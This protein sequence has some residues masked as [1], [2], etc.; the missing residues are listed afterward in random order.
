MFQKITATFACWLLSCAAFAQHKDA[1]FLDKAQFTTG[2]DP[3]WSFPGFDDKTWKTLQTGQVWQAQGFDN[4]HGFA[5]YRIHVFVPS[6]LREN[7]FWKDS[8]RL[9]L[10]HVNDVDETYFN[11]VKV[12]KTGAFPDDA[13]GYVSKW[14]ATREYHIA[15]EAAA[16]KW[17]AENIISIKVYDGGGTGGIFMGAPYIDMLEKTDGLAITMAA[18]DIRYDADKATLTLTVSN[19]YSVYFDGVLKTKIL[20]AAAHGIIT[21]KNAVLHI[22]PLD[23]SVFHFTVPNRP[24]VEISWS[25]TQ[26]GTT[27]VR[28]EKQT[29]PYTLTPSPADLPRIN[30]A[31]VLGLHPGSPVLFKIAATGKKP[32]R[33]AASGLP[34]GVQIDPSTGMIGGVVTDSGSYP[35]VI[36]VSNSLGKAQQHFNIVAG[37]RLALTPPMGWNS[38]NCWGIN[39]SAD[40]VMQSAQALI[41]KGLIDYGWTYINIDDGWQKPVR[42]TDSSVVPNEKFD[43]MMALGTWLHSRGLKFGIYSSPGPRTCGGY[44]GSYRN[45]EKDASTYAAWGVD[46]LKYDWCSYDEIAR[47]DSALT[48][49]I[50]PYSIMD[51]ALQKQKRD[52]V[53]NLCQYGMRD[54]WKW[55]SQVHAQSWRTTEDIEDTWQSFSSI[56]FGQARLYPYAGPGHWNDPDMMIVGKV[57]WG[58]DLHPTRLTPDEQYTHVSLWCLLSAPL[59][60][61]CD[62]SKLDA[63]TRNLLTNSEVLA[64]DQDVLGS[65]A[66][67]MVENDSTQVWVKQ[68]ADG[69][70]AIGVFNMTSGYSH[71][72]LPWKE[73]GFRRTQRVRDA[74][75]Q[76]SLGTVQNVPRLLLPPHGSVLLKLAS[77]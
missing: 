39:V 70:K 21:Q 68:L 4:Y 73:L 20:D 71:V 72:R 61:G 3:A 69:G 51:E 60:I 38:W 64:I 33:Y 32:L 25:F 74:W 40:K 13:G 9:F 18:E 26:T 7:A 19:S 66:Q 77:N 75:R 58:Q 57:G 37:A 42:A 11:G 22:R 41:D 43:D 62:L 45:E 30:S 53:Y 63:F 47:N 56:G 1:I 24:G 14:P 59:L 50:K 17:D 76:K 52:I 44:L 28:S 12:G 5:W 15:A 16:V 35:V 67:R 10:A 8:L 34:A 29:L 46:Y 65:Q 49:F 31:A 36:T 48:T 54:V 23:K 55:G 2:D 27:L 6:S